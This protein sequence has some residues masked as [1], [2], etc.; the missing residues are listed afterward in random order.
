MNHEKYVN[1]LSKDFG[2]LILRVLM[3]MADFP[4]DS[5]VLPCSCALSLFFMIFLS[6]CRAEKLYRVVSIYSN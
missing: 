3:K 5:A 1:G 6:A 2:L 4:A